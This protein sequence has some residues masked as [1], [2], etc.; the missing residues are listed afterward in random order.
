[1]AEEVGAGECKSIPPTLN[2]RRSP[3]SEDPEPLLSS[4]LL[5]SKL[6][7]VSGSKTS[8]VEPSSEKDDQKNV[9]KK[10]I[11]LST[12]IAYLVGG[13]IGSGVFVTPR[14]ILLLSHSF[15]LSMVVWI[16]GGMIAM[17]A[18]LCYIELGLLIGKSGVEYNFLKEAYT[19]KSK[20][21]LLSMLGEVLAFMY[22]WAMILMVRASS[23]AVVC[24][25]SAR[26]LVRP[27]FLEEDMPEEWVTLT[28]IAII[29]ELNERISFI[30]ELM[31]G[32]VPLVVL[33]SKLIS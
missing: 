7:D 18:G 3:S 20:H 2:Q 32:S 4:S 31:G 19:F 29:S 1:M 6:Q 16:L 27:F 13:T 26:Y 21:W 30:R 14:S 28:A 15:G 10:E 9:L 23:M 33:K 24:L 25:T 12:G 5:R 17:F 22:L 11:T 8:S